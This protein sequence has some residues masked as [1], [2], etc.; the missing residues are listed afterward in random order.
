MNDIW[1]YTVGREAVTATIELSGELDLSVRDPLLDVVTAEVERQ[2]T[3]TVRVDLAAVTFL[4][5][6]IIS[7][8]I[9]AYLKAQD[10]GK[11]FAIAGQSG[12]V[13]RILDT[14]GLSDLLAP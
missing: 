3:K 12:L 14:A 6:T 5:S 7:V 4:D 1:G 10:L 9:S 2:D 8:L 11:E 13:Q